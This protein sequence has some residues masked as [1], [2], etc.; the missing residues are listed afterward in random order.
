MIRRQRDSKRSLAIYQRQRKMCIRDRPLSAKQMGH[1]SKC[2]DSCLR[3][4]GRSGLCTSRSV[5]YTHLL[6]AAR[7]K[8]EVFINLHSCGS[9][10][11]WSFANRQRQ[12]SR[13]FCLTA[14]SANA[15]WNNHSICKIRRTIHKREK[16]IKKIPLFVGTALEKKGQ[17][18]YD[19][20]VRLW[21][22]R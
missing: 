15:G 8:C 20:Q 19:N 17:L 13:I 11:H 6:S 10:C 14:N 9:S 4:G 2:Q 5:S 22:G 12:A 7:C 21:C 18:C 1:W 16:E 3:D